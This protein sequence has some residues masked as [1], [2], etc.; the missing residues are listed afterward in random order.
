[1]TGSVAVWSKTTMDQRRLTMDG[2]SPA[3]K[4]TREQVTAMVA[5]RTRMT[6]RDDTAVMHAHMRYAGLSGE[7]TI[8]FLAWRPTENREKKSL[9][10]SVSAAPSSAA[11]YSTGSC[12]DVNPTAVQDLRHVCVSVPF[13]ELVA[14]LGRHPPTPGVEQRSRSG[15]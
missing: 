10:D 9:L 12:H 6:G 4:V 13:V 15:N 14:Q 3:M 5:T 2:P 8:C 11:R 1:M 7:A